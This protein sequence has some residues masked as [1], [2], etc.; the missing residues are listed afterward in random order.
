[1]QKTP[2]LFISFLLFT[3]LSISQDLRTKGK[4]IVNNRNEEVLL[5]GIG[6]GGWLLMEGYMMQTAGIAGTQHEFKNRLTD[7]MG[8]AKTEEFFD[9]W[10]KHHFTRRDVDSLANWGFNSIRVPIHYNLFTLPIEEEP[11]AGEQ[12][13]LTTGF[14]ILDSLLKWCEGNEMYLIIDL[15]AAPGGQGQN[16]DISDYDPTKP[17]LWES[18]ENKVKTVELWR[19]LAERYKEEPWIGGYDLINEPNWDLPGGEDL[20]D[21]YERIT[22]A[23]RNT[24]DEHI[25]FIE[26]NWFANDFTGLTPPWD[27]NMVYSFHKYWNTNLEG[28]LDWVLPMR[29]EHNVPLWMG[30][31]GENSNTWYTD[32][33]TLFESNNI[34]WSWWTM[35]KI[36]AINSPY[37]IKMPPGYQNII[38]YWKGEGPKPT[39]EEAWEGMMQLIENVK[40]ENNDYRPDV[41]DA[42]FRQVTT[43]ET[44]PYSRHSVPGTIYLPDF[45]QGKNEIA[46]HDTDVANYQL[47]TGEFQAWNGGWSYRNDG[48]DIEKNRDPFSNGHHIAFVKKGEW[49]NYTIHIEEE[50][51]YTMNARI[52]SEETGG[53]F[54][55]TLDN[56][57]ITPVQSVESTG[58]WTAF[59]NKEIPGILLPKGEHTL[60]FHVDDDIPFNISHIEIKRSADQ[61]IDFNVLL[62]ETGTSPDKIRFHFNYTLDPESI[63]TENFDIYI[64][65][66]SVDIL[67]FSAN[68]NIL[69]L[70]LE[71]TLFHTDEI[72]ADY[73]GS[74]IK[75]QENTPLESFSDLEIINNL[76]KRIRIPGKI[77][78]E[79][80]SNMSGFQLEDA[81]DT[82]GGKNLAYVNKGDYAEYPV[83][84]EKTSVYEIECRIAGLNDIGKFALYLKTDTTQVKITEI[85]TE[86]TGGWQTWE[87]IVKKAEL[88]Q[89]IY[90]LRLEILSNGEFNLNWLS[91]SDVISGI[92]RE[93]SSIRLYPNPT[94]DKLN[95]ITSGDYDY[96]IYSSTGT[97]KKRG[98]TNKPA[99]ISDLTPGIYFILINDQIVK[100]VKL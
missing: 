89:G 52:A 67:S 85:T 15:H 9:Q 59:Q 80:F 71:K 81:N 72:R 21:L 24:G 66:S 88:H 18:E 7:L 12:T 96:W 53:R 5:R 36:E 37:N 46:Y 39:E 75:N 63:R 60:T 48:V 38:D 90:T 11:V 65:D 58:S 83:L 13:W 73:S 45:D 22:E 50:G 3:S 31:S 86:P 69:E 10:R 99:D 34:G 8:E 56:V 87:S 91:F 77:E 79:D 64:N 49:S 19:K 4:V 43:D 47:S 32:A 92:G 76:E 20:R 54:H 41:I 98:M 82:G 94:H 100:F 16:A 42:L 29:E 28:D 97:I 84:I 57:A 6:P 14:T 68:G 2:L 95:F 23:I 61:A 35:R 27:S 44:I 93:Q 55:F 1:M 33:V 74:S 17:S 51:A 78:A 62:G 25:L 26:G 70:T 30:E 40:V